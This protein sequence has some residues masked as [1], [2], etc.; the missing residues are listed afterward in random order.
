LGSERLIAL[1]AQLLGE[2][3]GYGDV[4]RAVSTMTLV[5]TPLIN[6]SAR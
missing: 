5:F 1:D 6:A 3:A 2:F 4:G